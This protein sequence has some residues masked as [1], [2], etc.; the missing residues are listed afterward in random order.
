M[1]NVAIVITK[2]GGDDGTTVTS[3][4]GKQQQQKM[5]MMDRHHRHRHLELWSYS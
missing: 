1:A 4:I 2:V 5:N 3:A